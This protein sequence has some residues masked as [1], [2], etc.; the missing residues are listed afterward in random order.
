MNNKAKSPE[1]GDGKHPANITGSA[2]SRSSDQNR[3][4]IMNNDIGKSD[5]L[6]E[7]QNVPSEGEVAASINNTQ[8][9]NKDTKDDHNSSNRPGDDVE[10]IND[11][12]HIDADEDFDSVNDNIDFDD[13]AI[14]YDNEEEDLDN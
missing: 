3:S 8:G 12:E 2:E 4:G 1:T 14:E 11:N 9:I 7:D 13:D 10:L 5:D 6:F